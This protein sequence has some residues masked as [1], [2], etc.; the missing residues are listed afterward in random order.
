[1]IGWLI[2]L[3]LFLF[4]L[5]AIEAYYKWT[6]IR[7]SIFTLVIVGLLFVLTFVMDF[8]IQTTDEEIWSG[9]VVDWEHKEE[10]DE[11]IPPHT[12]CHKTKNGESCTTTPGY[13]K[14]HDAENKIKT[15]DNGWISVNKLPSGEI[16]DDRYPNTTEELKKYWKPGAPTASVHYYTNKVKAS[17]SIFKH[18]DIDLDDYPEIP[19]YPNKVDKNLDIDRIVGAVP[20]KEKASRKLSE[21]NTYLNEQIPDPKNKEKTISRKQVNIVFVN[22]GDVPDMNYGFALQ[23]KW[24]N[25][26]K[27]DYIISLSMKKD[28]TVN[29]VYPFTWSEVDELNLEVED[30]ILNQKKI[31]DFTTVVEGVGKLVDE[32]FE[33]KQFKDFNYLHVDLSEAAKII[34]WCI[35]LLGLIG[36]LFWKNKS[37]L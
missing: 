16:M 14:H 15:T 20:N 25:G 6:K 21:V 8:M 12:S 1:M 33:R 35:S 29:W 2:P 32:K 27:N 7:T 13:W 26:H 37:Q 24:Q 23:D 31:N 9:K 3:S 28:G 19:S 22:L 18:K 36:N 10:W 30:Y 4:G 34:L 17:Y 5:V 11:W